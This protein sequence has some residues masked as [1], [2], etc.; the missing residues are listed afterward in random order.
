MNIG[1]ESSR[2]RT[3]GVAFSVL[4]L[5][6]SETAA[7]VAYEIH[8]V[9]MG[10]TGRTA[11][12]EVII[13]GD[14]ARMTFSQVDDPV[15]HERAVELWL[16]GG[17]QDLVMD[18]EQQT[19]FDVAQFQKRIGQGVA[20]PTVEAFRPHV[21]GSSSVSVAN[22]RVDL[23]TD[24][25]AVEISGFLCTRAD[26]N[27]SYEVR[28][29]VGNERIPATV[30]AVIA[31]HVTESLA[32][33]RLPFGHGAISVSTGLEEPDIAIAARLSTL[34]GVAI[35]KVVEV[36]RQFQGSDPTTDT[37]TETLRGFREAVAPNGAFTVPSGYRYQE[38]VLVVPTRPGS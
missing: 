24:P 10:L 1:R 30:K 26:L 22:L 25:T 18:L 17:A 31:F 8:R 34:R 9:T 2:V 37:L 20:R 13:L 23:R 12:A 28:I 35:K 6:T 11:L 3:L 15:R 16:A 19:Y 5:A 7:D 14:N 32:V 4:I 33:S 29:F 36:T 38:P 21:P 27:V